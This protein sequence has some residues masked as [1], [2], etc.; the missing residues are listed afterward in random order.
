MKRPDEDKPILDCVGVG[1]CVADYQCLLDHYPAADEKTETKEFA[2]QGGAP[3]PTALIALAK[4]RRKVAFIGAAGDDDDGRFVK[5]ELERYGVDSS[6]LILCAGASTPK[7]FVW[8]DAAKGT[9]AVALAR[10][11][12]MA[13]PLSAVS[14]PNLPPC[15][16]LHTDGRETAASLRAMR[17]A[18]RRRAVT[19]ID[20]GSPR[21]RM[22]ELFAATDHFVASH[23][24]VRGYF[25]PRIKPAD[26][27][28]MILSR[29]PRVAVVTLAG[30]GC[31][32][33]SAD[34]VFR[35]EGR[36]KRGFIVDTTGAGDVFHGGY[37]HGLLS[38]WPPARCA[39]FANAAA[40][41]SCGALGARDGIPSLKQTLALLNK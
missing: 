1:L 8:I 21:D 34:G 27:L 3:V 6:R 12:A 36:H 15:R 33:A 25:G 10:E 19:V 32:G 41:L 37:I 9:R 40:F 5:N 23:S 24:F 35:V 28:G 20:A 30:N 13:M 4:W 7:A 11:P 18:R 14:G 22:D 16:V 2:H 26:A 38:G 29:G 31:V 39:E 17:A